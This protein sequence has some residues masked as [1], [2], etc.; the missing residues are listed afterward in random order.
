MIE[1]IMFFAGGFLVASLI[2]LVLIPSVHHR[3]IRL[4]E[5]RLADAIPVSMA[6][7]QADK[8][9]LRAEFA[10]TARRMEMNIEQLKARATAQLAEIAKKTEAIN[11]LKTELSEKTAITDDLDAKAKSLSAKMREVEQEYAAKSAA[12]EASQ[13]AIAAKEAELASTAKDIAEQRLASDTQ[14]VEIAVLKTQ[15]EQYKTQVDELQQEAKDAA[16][17]LFDERVTVSSANKELDEKRNAV[18]MLRPQVAQLERE[19]AVNLKDLDNR[20]RRIDEL[21]A[22]NT[23]HRQQLGERAAEINALRQEILNNRAEHNANA[24]RLNA[25]KSA[26]EKLLAAA[27]A[28]VKFHEQRINDL[29]DRVTDRDRILNQRDAEVSAL[30]REIADRKD[31]HNANIERLHAEKGTL[32][33]LL[34]AANATL[35]SQGERISDLDSRVAERDRLIHQRDEEASA[36]RREILESNNE[37]DAIVERLAGEKSALEKLLAAAN[38]TLQS[39]GDRIIDLDNRIAERDRLIHQ[40]DEEASALRREILDSNN[41]HKD[42]IERVSGEKAALDRLLAAAD[43]MLQSHS[44]RIVD[45]EH[46]LAERDRLIHQ[47]DEA[48][49]ALRREVLD[50][51][52]EHE[53]HIERVNAE[54]GTLERLLAAANATLQSH[55]ERIIDLDDRLAERDR[56][57][58]QRD[59]AANALRREILD[60]RSEHEAIV[61][62]LH[63]EKGALDRLLADASGTVDSHAARIDYLESWI[64]D[65]DRLLSQRDAEARA[66]QH[67]IAAAKEEHDA[68][69]ERLQAELSSLQRLLQTATHTL[70][71]RASRIDDLE[72]W[73]IERDDLL[74]KRDAQ[75]RELVTQFTAFKAEA[76]STEEKLRTGWAMAQSQLQGANRDRDQAQGELAALRRDA[77]ATWMAERD[78]AAL[79]RKRINEFAAQVAQMVMTAEKAGPIDKILTESTATRPEAFERPAS[80]GSKPQPDGDLAERLRRL[81]NGGSRFHTP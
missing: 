9:N 64:T 75:I 57:I 2:A 65:R 34:A 58:S 77:E 33:K 51:N 67:E 53:A 22:L 45:L 6:E 1:T 42:N 3:A 13:R 49:A 27:N 81:R 43:A 20:S 4:T 47:R 73:S 56:L 74:T 15:L 69:L 10:M 72:A 54:K 68:A 25:E 21:E 17:R 23:D 24:E 62:R 36:F 66:L 78:D 28:T 59:E 8:D 80:D 38:A 52:N 44:D 18:E 29:D 50:S 39:H 31:E 16:R 70:E 35:Q 48:A 5:R 14:R 37:H 7:F 32:E 63:Q 61:E 76:N 79:L 55:G 26:L 60:N 30:R 46:R 71:T 41:E 40:R 11:R 19:I 12:I